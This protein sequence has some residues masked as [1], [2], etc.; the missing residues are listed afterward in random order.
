M[1]KEKLRGKDKYETAENYS[2]AG[3]AVGVVLIS[4]GFLLTTFYPKGIPV[5]L[6]MIGSFLSF[7]F[8]VA[9]VFVWLLK[10]LKV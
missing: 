7:I 8:T 6:L 5:I 2:I 10:E 3:I 1:W 4:M 9:I